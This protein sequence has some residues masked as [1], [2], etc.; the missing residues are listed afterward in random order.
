MKNLTALLSAGL[1]LLGMLHASPAAPTSQPPVSPVTPDVTVVSGVAQLIH[2]VLMLQFEKSS[3]TDTQYYENGVWHF[4][5]EEK[6]RSVQ[7]GPASAAAVLWKWQAQH[8]GDLPEAL[9]P[10]G[11]PEKQEWLRRIAVETLDRSIQDHCRP[12]GEFA[13]QADSQSP[14]IAMKFFGVELGAAYLALQDTL[15]EPTRQRWRK[16]LTGSVNFLLKNGNL[17]DGTP[18]HRNWYTNGN[19]ELGEA[20]LLYLTWKATGESKYQGLFELQWG[21]MLSPL[22]ERWK[23][24]GLRYSKEPAKDDGS[25]GAGY[26]AEKGSGEP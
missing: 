13:P 2:D 16:T 24:F 11:T 25:D 15:D 14:E 4:K 18:G 23:G 5:N 21:F 3:D 19:I 17:S 22:Q 8:A 9:K 12:T 7:G 26:L 20:E 1:L 10:Q 6:F